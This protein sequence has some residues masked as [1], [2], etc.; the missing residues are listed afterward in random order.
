[1]QVGLTKAEQDTLSVADDL[2]PLERTAQESGDSE[3]YLQ[4]RGLHMKERLYG[5]EDANL[6]P[7]LARLAR[8]LLGSV[9]PSPSSPCVPS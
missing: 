3:L 6:V 4:L 8:E 7:S 1:V 5:H 9:M 2:S